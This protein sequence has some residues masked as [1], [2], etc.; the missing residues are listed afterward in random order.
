MMPRLPTLVLRRSGSGV[1]LLALIAV[2]VFLPAR[3]VLLPAWPDPV[4]EVLTQAGPGRIERL[5][6][7]A[8]SNRPFEP[9]PLARSRPL[10][11]W[12]LEY[13]TG[14]VAHAWLAGVRDGDGQ[15]L[16]ALPAWLEPVRLDGPLPEAV[17]LVVITSTRESREIEG[18]S[19]VRMYRPNGMNIA[20]RAA[21]WRDRIDERWQWPFRLTGGARMRPP[22]Q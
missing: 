8:D 22:A 20:Q 1:A 12:R 19:I 3:Q 16:P 18:E 9:A 2:G 6:L 7:P 17:R 15:L 14:T 5:F 21:L 10:T 11:L 4:E 13:D